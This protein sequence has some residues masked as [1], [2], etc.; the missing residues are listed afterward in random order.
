MIKT[1]IKH[2]E[3]KEKTQPLPAESGISPL[4]YAVFAG[5][6]AAVLI[7]LI[8]YLLINSGGGGS[9]VA[10]KGAKLGTQ[11]ALPLANS[12]AS[13]VTPKSAN[14]SSDNQ[15]SVESGSLSS[16]TFNL[17]NNVPAGQ[18]SV[19]A[20]PLQASSSTQSTAA[21]YGL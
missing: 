15:S 14:G 7:A 5:C 11:P 9:V 19:Q 2:Q 3:A 16:S 21:N 10:A 20:S 13:K 17:Q 1:E 4:Q 8:V 18:G 12:S 6:F